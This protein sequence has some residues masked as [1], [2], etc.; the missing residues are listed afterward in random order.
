MTATEVRTWVERHGGNV[1]ALARRLGVHRSRL[2]DWMRD[3]G[4]SEIP[5][6]IVAHME[7]IDR[8]EPTAS[9]GPA[10]GEG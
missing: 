10:S 7:T 1:S 9:A 5:P 4:R 6:Y 8:H 2:H 3:Y